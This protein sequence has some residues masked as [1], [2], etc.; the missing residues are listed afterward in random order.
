MR[1]EDNSAADALLRLAAM[2]PRQ[3][4]AW[5]MLLTAT[6]LLLPA[7]PVRGR[8]KGPC[9]TCHTMHRSQNRG[10]VSDRADAA[11]TTATPENYTVTN[12]LKNVCIGCHS[13]TTSDT[14]VDLGDGIRVP[15]VYN[16]VAPAKPLAG[17]NFFW[18]DENGDEYGH[19]VR[20]VDSILSAA[21]DGPNPTTCAFGGCHRSLASIQY[22]GGP[23]YAAKQIK[24]NGCIACHNPA[25]HVDDTVN[26]RAGGSKYVD[27]S[28]G[29]YRFLNKAAYKFFAIPQ[30]GTPAVAGIEAADW[31]QEP[32]A[33]NHN[34]YQDNTKPS[35]PGQY[36]TTPEGISD[37]CGG[38]HR[39]FHS[40][41]ARD[42]PN[43]GDGDNPWIRHPAAI[44]LPAT[45][46]YA[47][48]TTYDPNVP[49]A[50]PDSATLSAYAGPSDVVTP[51]S[52]KVM[53]LSC[54]RAHG[55]PYKDMLR[56]S[57]ATMV[58]SGGGSGGCFVCHSSKS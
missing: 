31:Q 12:L 34:E 4:M 51:G 20:T 35:L 47:A 41:P 14:I 36:G 23:V 8:V 13:S 2:C 38:C 39:N 15:I 58:A 40:W 44:A 1:S 11:F 19:N 37:F 27:G 21:P 17:G 26:M 50:R 57:Y 42:Y 24:G 53:C 18:V 33:T 10:A 43:G 46:E 48:Y 30:H 22:G 54:H 32:S 7:S 29:G 16:P 55:S 9:Y 56:W 45:G 25:H 52:D 6:V 3:S 28:G 49:V 5:A